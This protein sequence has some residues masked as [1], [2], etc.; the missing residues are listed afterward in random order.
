MSRKG[1]IQL[2]LLS[3]VAILAAVVVASGAA[4]SS[5]VAV[6]G[7]SSSHALRAFAVAGTLTLAAELQVAYPFTACPAGT[8]ISV[9]CYSRTGTG[10]VRG[11]GKVDES[12]TYMVDSLPAGCSRDQVRLPPTTMRLRVLGKGELE[13]R[14]AGTGCVDRIPTL[15]LRAE[16]AFTITGGT[17][18][19][20]GA[21][22]GGTYVDVSHGPPDFSGTDTWNGTLVVP[23][24][25]FDLTPPQLT[26]GAN[27]TIRVPKR[28][29]RVR[30]AFAVAAHDDIEGA[31]PVK[32][33]PRSRSWFR[34]GRTQVRCSA[35]DS[36]ANE[37]KIAF[38]VTVK[39][40]R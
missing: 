3:C 5:P 26:G 40:R 7:P 4:S 10:S 17:G 8:P 20:V 25:E 29:R 19:Y 2:W 14:M 15:P 34:V 22:G 21:S 31:L 24:L 16:A 9:E 30:V 35:T 18:R 27:R 39:R 1:W 33:R 12:Y 32:C 6:N 13:L 28:V 36:S 11:L 37:S 23:G 38:V